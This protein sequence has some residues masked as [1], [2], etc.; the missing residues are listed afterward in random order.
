MRPLSLVPALGIF[1]VWIPAA[2]LRLLHGSW[3]RAIILPGG[4]GIIVGSVDNLLRPMFVDNRL[5]LHAILAF[6]SITGGLLLLGAP[7]FL[8]GPLAAMM[9]MLIMGFWAR[10]ESANETIG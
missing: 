4:G 2:M 6:I 7:G 5:Q 10:L 1:I 8:L 9:R 3:I